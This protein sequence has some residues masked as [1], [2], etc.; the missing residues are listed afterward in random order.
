LRFAPQ[1]PKNRLGLIL[2]L[3]F[4]PAAV[5]GRGG[6]ETPEKIVH[7]SEW[8]L[9][10]T[11]F[12]MSALP[13]NRR[14][15]G[16]VMTRSLLDA[17]NAVDRRIRVSREYAYYEGYA[18]SQARMAAARALAARQEERDLLIYRGEP[19]WRYRRSLKT[20]DE[21]IVKLKE[22]LAKVEAEAP[23]VAREPV[24]QFTEGNTTGT[25]PAPPGPGGEY[26]F[27]QG[28][29]ADGFLSGEIIE[30]HSRL[31]ITIRLYTLYTQSFVYEDDIIFSPDDIQS[32]VDEI[33]GR[34]VAILTG[35]SPALI[36]I[37]AEPEDTLVLIN[38]TFAG[39]GEIAPRE[40]P[41]GTVTV[42][43]SAEGHAP[44]AVETELLPGETT[45]IEASLR[46]LE[47]AQVD[48]DIP[49][50][51]GAL[52]YRGA[53]YVG[54]APLTLRLPVNQFDY[55]HV[56]T[57]GLETGR[58]VFRTPNV[59]D[60]RIS[61]SLK[62]NISPPAGQKRVDRAR[63]QYYWAWGATWIAGAA[64]WMSY[65]LFT[66]HNDALKTGDILLGKW[67]DEFY[68]QTVDWYNISNVSLYVL[69]AVAA[70]DIFQLIRYMY[71]SGRDAAPIK[72]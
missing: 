69:G 48:I 37:R 21:A 71:I 8:R 70:Y 68:N 15:V 66:T 34:L 27:C 30:F 41:P 31:Y 64:A 4:L 14:I 36:A 55:V 2:A 24:F 16:E 29:K 6:T 49:G 47:L 40:H 59:R 9:C 1:F 62:T 42:S 19:E 57:P 45:E 67:N 18:W 11:A 39:R 17:V 33:A 65:G 22:D 26:R 61:L 43:L 13:E 53:M 52:V 35:S 20:I 28:Q 60:E 10:V 23:L 46:P 7:N 12:D 56:E 3:C 58:M 25:F 32:A 50:K 72:R 54:E 51:T 5:F 63:R 38:R 44:Q